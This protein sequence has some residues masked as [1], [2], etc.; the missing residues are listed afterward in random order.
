M[1]YPWLIWVPRMI[2]FAIVIISM[3]ASLNVFTFN[4]PPERDILRYLVQVIPA[5]AYYAAL[6]LTWKNAFQAGAA[7]GIMTSVHAVALSVFQTCDFWQSMGIYCVPLLV[8]SGMFIYIHFHALAKP[9]KKYR[10]IHRI[11]GGLVIFAK[12]HSTHRTGWTY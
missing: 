5:L 3:F 12:P 6:N 4:C 10:H 9:R 1:K 11:K 2:V 8:A 7:I